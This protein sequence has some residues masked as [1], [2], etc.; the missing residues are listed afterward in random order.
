MSENFDTAQSRNEAILQ[1]ILG[2]NNEILPPFSRIETLLIA[3]LELIAEI[4][5]SEMNEV[6]V[7]GTTPT[8]AAENNIAY[9]CGE[10]TTLDITSFP[11]DGTFIVEFDSGTTATVLEIDDGITMPEDFTVEANYHYEINVRKGYGLANG[12][13]V[14]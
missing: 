6:E 2:A 8:I 3:L 13:A 11:E 7:S 9:I 4:E 1:N 14:N 10:V 12:W 5:A